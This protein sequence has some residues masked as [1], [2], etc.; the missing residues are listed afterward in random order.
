VS[1][2]LPPVNNDV[3]VDFEYFEKVVAKAK[4]YLTALDI[5]ITPVELKKAMKAIEEQN[6]VKNIERAKVY[7]A[8][9]GVKDFSEDSLNKGVN[10][11]REHDQWLLEQRQREEE[12]VMRSAILDNKL[13]VSE[14]E[15]VI[16]SAILD[17]KRAELKNAEK[18]CFIM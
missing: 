10:Y 17:I 14:E 5:A 18:A 13:K 6:D 12:G 8:A 4:A 1:T 15:R 9:L 16:Q 2:T 3:D 11:V 7:L